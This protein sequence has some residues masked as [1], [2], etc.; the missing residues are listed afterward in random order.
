MAT[1]KLAG[2]LS[3]LSISRFTALYFA[4][5]CPLSDGVRADVGGTRRRR[6]DKSKKKK[7]KKKSIVSIMFCKCHAFRL[8]QHLF[9]KW[10]AQ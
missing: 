7:K 6:R 8:T 3:C 10:Q 5:S 1:T 2:Y 9:P 4:D